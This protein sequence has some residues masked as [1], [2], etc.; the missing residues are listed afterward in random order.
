MQIRKEISERVYF[1]SAY[2]YAFLVLIGSSFTLTF[3]VSWF[4]IQAAIDGEIGAWL[5]VFMMG[6]SILTVSFSFA[7][8]WKQI[9][10]Y[11]DFMPEGVRAPQRG[12]IRVAIKPYSQYRYVYI[13]CY[14]HGTLVGFGANRFF[15]LFSVYPI[16]TSLLTKINSL[17]CSSELIKMRI[18]KTNMKKATR[19]LS[20]V[21]KEKVKS[22]LK[23]AGLDSSLIDD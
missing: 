13:G 23:T 6:V 9:Y 3:L 15:L 8:M 11:W 18:T 20:P 21:M 2:K 12:R 1:D 17:E 4:A 5:V 14:R 22:V 10:Y 16:P 19:F 7:S